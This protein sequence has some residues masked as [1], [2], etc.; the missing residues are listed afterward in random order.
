MQNNQYCDKEFTQ[1]RNLSIMTVQE[2][3]RQRIA[4][5]LHDTS[6][7]TLA[8]LVHK[9]ELCNLYIDKDVFQAKLEILSV[10][11]SLKDVIEEI[12]NTIFD[13]RPMSF[14]DLGVE[15]TFNRFIEREN[16]DKKFKIISD[17]E[18]I[19]FSHDLLIL[20]LYRAIQECVSNAIKH[21]EGTEIHITAKHKPCDMYE[22]I[23]ADNGK[24]FTQEEAD[25]KT[26]H[27]GLLIIKERVSILNGTIDI[28]SEIGK[29][30]KIIIEFPLP[31]VEKNDG[32]THEH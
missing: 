3:E 27:F 5:D 29:G 28:Q 4:R 11:Q 23:I 25:E 17:V 13:L 26:N 10:R 18:K 20:T 9:L 1:K 2:E 12:R 8:H 16:P 22:V 15:E 19:E 31:N 21:S 14:D 6:L 7:Q 24:G 32:G 30:T